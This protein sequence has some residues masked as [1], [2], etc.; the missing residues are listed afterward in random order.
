MNLKTLLKQLIDMNINRDHPSYEEL[1][2]ILSDME[3]NGCN[4]SNQLKLR[5]ELKNIEV[6]RD[7]ISNILELTSVLVKS[8]IPGESGV[9]RVGVLESDERTRHTTLKHEYTGHILKSEEFYKNTESYIGIKNKEFYINMAIRGTKQDKLCMSEIKHLVNGL[10]SEIEIIKKLLLSVPLNNDDI[11]QLIQILL[12]NYFNDAKELFL[13]TQL[14]IDI[15]N[16]SVECMIGIGNSDSLDLVYQIISNNHERLDPRKIEHLICHPSILR[17]PNIFSKFLNKVAKSDIPLST[18]IGDTIINYIKG[19]VLIIEDNRQQVFGIIKTLVETKGP[20]GL[21]IFNINSESF[22]TMLAAKKYIIGQEWLTYL[23]EHGLNPLEN[24]KVPVITTDR[25]S[26]HIDEV[27]NKAREQLVNLR[28][29]FL[30]REGTDQI[31]FH[32]N[33]INWANQNSENLESLANMPMDLLVTYTL[34]IH[35]KLNEISSYI[36]DL[37][38]DKAGLRKQS[39]TFAGDK[40]AIGVRIGEG[41][42][43][44]TKSLD[45]G[46]ALE[47]VQ[48]AFNY[49]NA[50][51]TK[52]LPFNEVFYLMWVQACKQ[53][54]DNHMPPYY[55]RSDILKVLAQIA[56]EYYKNESGIE[57]VWMPSC[58]GGSF[59]ILLLDFSKPLTLS[60]EEHYNELVK[61]EKERVIKEDFTQY[62]VEEFL[63]NLSQEFLK[64]LFEGIE[65]PSID[66]W[67]YKQALTEILNQALHNFPQIEDADILAT[68]K[69]TMIEELLFDLPKIYVPSSEGIRICDY[70]KNVFK[71]EM[72][73]ESTIEKIKEQLN[74]L[75]SKFYNGFINPGKLT[76]EVA[77]YITKQ[78]VN[79]GDFEKLDIYVANQVK[80]FTAEH[81]LS[82]APSGVS[83]LMNDEGVQLLAELSENNEVVG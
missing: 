14:P 47:L 76:R 28:K 80:E 21:P 65:R 67:R 22:R 77:E 70:F 42:N 1:N 48:Q 53:E 12:S 66:N 55:Y 40:V 6:N 30:T 58:I 56:C 15:I 72:H 17:D 16:P 52:D 32:Q 69:L 13:S 78:G 49:F 10:N 57:S 73:D 41:A 39:I 81:N 3:A 2:R 33:V 19:R 23:Y 68:K 29:E 20:S 75:I 50:N 64:V 5:K 45:T 59:N 79:L 7:N 31:C 44:V 38:E 37:I 43:T 18:D 61:K 35:Q 74:L 83:L 54:I 4:S 34:Y 36:S 27:S 62:V 82:D 51:S 60:S 63:P 9:I 25:Q 11:K 24:T 26:A 71:Q 46:K 8:L